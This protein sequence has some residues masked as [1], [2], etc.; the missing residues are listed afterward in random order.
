MYSADMTS[1]LCT[2]LL[3][4]IFLCLTPLSH[5]LWGT[6]GGEIVCMTV[7]G[8]YG[9]DAAPLPTLLVGR[10][11]MIHFLLGKHFHRKH[12]SNVNRGSGGVWDQW[13]RICFS[14]TPWAKAVGFLRHIHT[15]SV[16]CLAFSQPVEPRE[17]RTDPRTPQVHFTLPNKRGFCQSRHL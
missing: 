14:A 9:A 3:S 15:L 7:V 4:Q 1:Q 17:Q 8:I 10:G 16:S 12:L 13:D 2:R 11:S 6:Q 5:L